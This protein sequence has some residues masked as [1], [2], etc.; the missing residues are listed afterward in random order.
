MMRSS[1]YE[2]ARYITMT[3]LLEAVE[4]MLERENITIHE[5][6]RKGD[7]SMHD[8]VEEY[9]SDFIMAQHM[10]ETPQADPMFPIRASFMESIYGSFEWLTL[11]QRSRLRSVFEEGEFKLCNRVVVGLSALMEEAVL[12]SNLIF[13]K[14]YRMGVSRMVRSSKKEPHMLAY[15]LAANDQD[16]QPI[17]P[18][19]SCKVSRET[20]AH[21]ERRYERRG[22][23][24]ERDAAIFSMLF[25]YKALGEKTHNLT[26]DSSRYETLKRVSGCD[27]EPFASPFNAF[28]KYFCSVFPDVDGPFGSQGNFFHGR[29]CKGIY[30]I[31]PVNDPELVKMTISRCME[32]VRSAGSESSESLTLLVGTVTYPSEEGYRE[33][34]SYSRDIRSWYME[35]GKKP[36][37]RDMMRDPLCRGCYI[38]NNRAFKTLDPL[39]YSTFVSKLVSIVSV[40]SSHPI[41]MSIFREMME[42]SHRS[43]S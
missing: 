27:F 38:L 33:D 19:F 4:R 10:F 43:I 21:L 14:L 17:E 40:I 35:K 13:N 11:Q 1:E 42:A 30:S 23:K 28:S 12:R 39:T 32:M 22:D 25:R 34:P 31:N 26:R 9:I 5:Q 6:R 18:F 2:L 37:L 29:L 7:L 24:E 15:T 20:I 3:F 41:D 16:G 8:H 36:Y